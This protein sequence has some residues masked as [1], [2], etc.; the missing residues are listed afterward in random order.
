MEIIA[1]DLPTS[2]P[3]CAPIACEG[4]ASLLPI[5]TKEDRPSN[6]KDAEDWD[7]EIVV[8]WER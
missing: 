5:L 4:V 3:K 8:H 2:F 6:Q 7:D 1:W